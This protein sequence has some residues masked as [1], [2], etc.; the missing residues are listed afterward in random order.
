MYTHSLPASEDGIEIAVV[1][2]THGEL[3][4]PRHLEHEDVLHRH[5]KDI[6]FVI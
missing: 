3:W 1:V 5:N 6:N 4:Q 2:E